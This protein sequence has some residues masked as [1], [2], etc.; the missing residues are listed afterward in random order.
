MITPQARALAAAINRLVAN[1]EAHR[2]TQRAIARQLGRVH[3]TLSQ[4]RDGSRVPSAEHLEALLAVLK[5]S[6][7]DRRRVM[8]LHHQVRNAQPDWSGAA[9]AVMSRLNTPATDAAAVLNALADYCEASP[10]VCA[11]ALDALDLRRIATEL[12]E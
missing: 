5:V 6:D 7:A 2:L 3:S 11:T 10:S 4:W 1:R 8:Y 12:A 9:R